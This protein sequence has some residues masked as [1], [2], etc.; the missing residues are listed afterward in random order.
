M[1]HLPELASALVWP[2]NASLAGVL[3]KQPMDTAFSHC[4]GAPS[5]SAFCLVPATPGPA[6]PRGSPPHADYQCVLPDPRSA[7]P[8]WPQATAAPASSMRMA[9]EWGP[10]VNYASLQKNDTRCSIR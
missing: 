10:S 6:L 2:H 7:C 1:D 4:K 5:L 9:Y 3:R 8:T